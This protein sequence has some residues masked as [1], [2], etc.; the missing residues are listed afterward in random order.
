MSR[1]RE[2]RR[3]ATMPAQTPDGVPAMLALGRC[4]EVWG[5]HD[6]DAIGAFHAW[7]D[8]RAEW[9]EAHGINADREYARL[10]DVLL[11]HGPWSFF[12]LA[13]NDPDRLAERL[14]RAGLS[15]AWRPT[16]TT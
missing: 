14:A 2:A 3:A 12:D 13:E 9:A 16:T 1:R 11:D 7:Y 8:A 6:H 15:P 4:I 10:P 5:R